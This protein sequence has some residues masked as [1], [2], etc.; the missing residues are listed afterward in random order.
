MTLLC[1]IRG[2][3]MGHPFLNKSHMCHCLHL[4]YNFTMEFVRIWQHPIQ[5]LYY[6]VWNWYGLAPYQCN[7]IAD[8]LLWEWYVF[9]CS[10]YHPHIMLAHS[11][12]QC[13][14]WYMIWECH[15]L[16]KLPCH[17]HISQPRCQ[18]AIIYNQYFVDFHTIPISSTHTGIWYGNAMSLQTT[19]QIPYHLGTLTV[20]YR[21]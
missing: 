21:F 5:S 19:I 9:G 13:T 7:M 17:S 3:W 2:F 6:L 10:P 14:K 18:L 1:V 12:N 4:L 15:V 8:P 11:A 16:C 20:L